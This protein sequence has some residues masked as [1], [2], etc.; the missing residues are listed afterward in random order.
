MKKWLVLAFVAV[1][2]GG[3]MMYWQ[4]LDRDVRNLILTFPTDRDILFWTDEQRDY[5]F[6]AI[7]KVSLVADSRVIESG[8]YTLALPT[9]T[10]LAFDFDIEAQIEAHQLSGIVIVHNGEIRYETYRRGFKDTG[11]WTSFSVAKSITSTLVGAAIKDGYIDSLDDRLPKYLPGLAG[12]AYDEVSIRQLLTMT[13]GVRWN[14]DYS[15]PNSDVAQFNNHVPEPGVDTTISYMR[16]LEREAPAGEK[17]VYKTGETNLIG[18]LVNRATGKTLAQY[19]SEKIWQPYGME[20]DATW[21][22]SSSGQEISGCCIQATIRDFARVGLFMLGGGVANGDDVLPEGWLA[23]ATINHVEPFSADYGYGYQWWTLDHGAYM[24]RGIFG[25][26]IFIDPV[27][28]L[29]IASNGNWPVASDPKL[30]AERLA[31]YRAV[32]AAVDAEASGL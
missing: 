1:F 10:P 2:F 17:W 4:T 29:V 30:M 28:N 12:S 16:Q 19:A 32:Q 27:R 21:L 23:E 18:L 15:D 20:A 5:A 24:A 3:G 8:D 11:R 31:F 13:S 6:R 7:D 25:Q 9:G 26:G 14:E 22:L